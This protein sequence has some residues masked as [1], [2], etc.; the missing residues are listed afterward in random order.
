MS[1]P[2]RIWLIDADNLLGTHVEW[3]DT[4]YASVADEHDAEY[5]R[6]DLVITKAEARQLAI[7]FFHWFWNQPGTNAEQGFDEFYPKWLADKE[8]DEALAAAHIEDK[9]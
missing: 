2:E 3:R 7:D 4:S 1:S 6:S 8:G 5:T 9:G